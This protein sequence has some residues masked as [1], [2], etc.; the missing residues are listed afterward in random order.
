M[1]PRFGQ[2]TRILGGVLIV[3][4]A[5]ACFV[6]L[7]AGSQTTPGTSDNGVVL[8]GIGVAYAAAGVGVWVESVWGW[9]FGAALT[10]FVV[11]MDLVLGI[12]DGG[13]VVW[14]GL[15]VAFVVTAVQGFFDRAA[16]R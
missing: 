15:L 5:G 8:L 6:G 11:V 2:L 16:L 1:R 14:T 13:L 4:G 7:S 3:T 12:V 9:W 10:T